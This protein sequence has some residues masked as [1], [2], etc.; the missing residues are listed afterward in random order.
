MKIKYENWI[1][2]FMESWKEL[3]YEHTLKT[4][5]ENVQYYENPIDEPCQSFEEVINL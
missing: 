4:L 1:K 2:E 3:D 5:D